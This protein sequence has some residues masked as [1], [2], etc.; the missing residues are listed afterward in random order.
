M[1]CNSFSGMPGASCSAGHAPLGIRC[2][3]VE[4]ILEQR[5]KSNFSRGEFR[6]TS[7]RSAAPSAPLVSLPKHLEC[8]KGTVGIKGWQSVAAPLASDFCKSD[9]LQLSISH[10][11]LFNIFNVHKCCQRN[12]RH[13]GLN[14]P[15]GITAL[16]GIPP[17]YSIK[18]GLW[19]TYPWELYRIKHSYDTNTIESKT[20]IPVYTP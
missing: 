20:K 15:L 10:F 19:G 16:G 1:R 4:G 12:S 13:N 14:I 18:Q 7:S 5:A 9:H 11:W 17:I 8:S 6:K 3:A 2:H